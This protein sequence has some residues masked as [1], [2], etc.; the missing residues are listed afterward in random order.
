MPSGVYPRTKE[1]NKH[2]SESL[3][4]K[5]H[6]EKTRKLMSD[7]HKGSKNHMF[8]VKGSNHH[9]YGITPPKHVFD[10]LIKKIA[11]EWLVI[12]PNGEE[13]IVYNLSDFCRKHDLNKGN[14]GS[15]ACGR[16]E[17]HKGYKCIKL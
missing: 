8:G 9:S 15:T 1:H 13:K 7:N 4:G 11:C 6:S 14:M 3:K 16:R 17:H 12:F 10:A 5:S 2:I